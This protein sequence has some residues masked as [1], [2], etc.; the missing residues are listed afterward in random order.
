MS[1]RAPWECTF[2]KEERSRCLPGNK[3]RTDR[4]YFEVLSL[5]ILQ[6]GLSWASVRRSW[7]RYRSAFLN[8]EVAKLAHAAPAALLRRPGALRN[9]K[10]V[11]A[12]VA[13]A[14]EFERIRAE[15][16]T[17]A[18][19]LRAVKSGKDACTI[20]QERF[21]QVGPYTAEFYLHC[22]GRSVYAS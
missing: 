7:P 2:A 14:Q 4:E 1:H 8:F 5:C 3:P 19:Y 20:L 18:R 9:R 11:A 15:H 16:G 6:A 13:N 21:R 10:K 22:V 17:F 12:L